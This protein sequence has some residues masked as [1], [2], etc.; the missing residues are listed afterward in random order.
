MS[1]EVGKKCVDM[2]FDEYYKESR[3]L[4]KHNAKA[5]I[6]DFI[7]GEPLLEIDLIDYIVEYFRWKATTLNHPWAFHHMICISTNGILYDNPKVKSFLQ[8]NEG[9]V[10]MSITIDGCKDLHDACRR[11]PDGAGSYDIVEKAV[12]DQIQR[13]NQRQTKLTLAPQNL[14]YFFK[15]IQNLYNLGLDSVFANC[16][17]EEG[18][19]YKD[20]NLLYNQM[21]LISDWIIDNDIFYEF[22]VGI[23]DE[24][25]G[26]KLPENENKN[27]CGGT[28]LMLAFDPN[29]DIYPC[30]RYMQ[31]STGVKVK[32]LIIGNVDNGIEHT[33]EQCQIVDYLKRID[34]K[35]QS[36]D[37]CYNCPIGSGCSWCS[38]YNYQITGDP[39]KRVTY[40]CI[41]HQA[42]V[43]A[44][45]YFWQKLYKKLELDKEFPLNV[46]EEWALKIIDKDEF[47][48]LKNM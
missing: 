38:A 16:I 32:P 9:R 11:F 29:G 46:P 47:D 12:K 10:S 1:K 5:I 19:E 17:Y 44:N 8:R 35:S 4:N 2:L 21:K 41:M 7:G 36:T 39:N 27:W 31:F 15:A 24:D 45:R 26:F 34:R 18:W 40:I 13:F 48:M 22:K 20:A 30:L 6:L 37:E 25:I 23:F 43:L 14:K 3:Y 28:G 42:R 33:C